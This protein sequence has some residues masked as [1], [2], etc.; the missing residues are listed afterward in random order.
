MIG[1]ASARNLDVV[2]GLGAT[3]LDYRGDVPAQVRALAP[4]G[5]D[6][7]F[8]HVGGPGIVDSF[9]LLAPGGALRR[10]R[11]RVHQGH[12]RQPEARRC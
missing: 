1:T 2:T 8:D 9:R 5:V 10:L 6:A 7:V 3:A 4:G 11:Q 12:R